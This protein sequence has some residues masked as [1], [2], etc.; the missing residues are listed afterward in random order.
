MENKTKKSTALSIVLKVI[1]TLVVIAVIFIAGTFISIILM[2]E[3]IHLAITY[4]VSYLPLALLLPVIWLKN[5]K[6]YIKFWLVAGVL[7]VVVTGVNFGMVK[8]DKSIKINTSAYAKIYENIP[9]YYPF[10]EDTKIVKIDSETLKLT[11]DLPV[12]DGETALFP[13]YSAF[14]NAVYPESTEIYDGTFDYSSQS[15][16]E[17][18]SEWG[19]KNVADNRTD[20]FFDLYPTKDGEAYAQPYGATLEYTT[21]GTEALVFFVHKDNP[22]DTLS[23]EQIRGIYSGEIT[24]WEDVGGKNKKIAAYQSDTGSS[25]Q[26]M[27]ERFMGEIPLMDAPT[28]MGYEEL[29][30]WAEGIA[31]Y[32]NKPNA[33]GF[34][35]R[36]LVEDNPN[37][38]LISIDGVAP[39]Q[40]NIKDGSYSIVTPIY[41]V[42]RE[43]NTCENVDKLLDWILS[44]EGQY[45]I[46]ESGYTGVVSEYFN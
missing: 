38:K 14:I 23:I 10:V 22:I 11:E 42:T 43:G 7:C 4:I 30:L 8:Y 37:I 6:K 13:V 41:A 20:I 27:M 26:K 39:T 17:Y 46:E 25:S 35:F 18:L 5:R 45:I 16:Y 34:S 44:E 31:E 33:I 40:E 1:L 36:Y 29:Y 15:A 9:D 2:S 32:R 24:N 12:I 21:I 28:K 19:Y 3:D